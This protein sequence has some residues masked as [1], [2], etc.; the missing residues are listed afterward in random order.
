MDEYINRV[1]YFFLGGLV[2][3]FVTDLWS[4][5]RDEIR[6]DLRTWRKLRRDVGKKKRRDPTESEKG[7]RFLAIEYD[8][9]NPPVRGSCGH[10][11][12]LVCRLTGECRECRLAA[13]RDAGKR[14]LH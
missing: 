10:M 13:T 9:R 7:Q 4:R 6:A 11:T 14:S 1:V 5:K 2:T 12:K 8:V 3:F